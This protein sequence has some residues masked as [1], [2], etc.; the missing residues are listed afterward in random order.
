MDYAILDLCCAVECIIFVT[1]S[2]N[3]MNTVRS[4]LPTSP[5]RSR[6]RFALT[7]SRP[8]LRIFSVTLFSLVLPGLTMSLRRR[9]PK[10]QAQDTGNSVQS[11][12]SEVERERD[13]GV[14]P[15]QAASNLVDYAI[16]VSLV[17]GGC[18]S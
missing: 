9:T 16:I 7:C 11:Q 2:P 17:L 18:C 1:M 3:L 15:A 10:T 13:P 14:R 4:R 6:E 8:R 12:K 5:H